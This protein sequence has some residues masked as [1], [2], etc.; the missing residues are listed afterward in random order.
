MAS[1]YI[2][3]S[4]LF[5]QALDNFSWEVAVLALPALLLDPSLSFFPAVAAQSD[6]LWIL[7]LLI[8][9]GGAMQM[10][11]APLVGLAAD[12]W[13]IRRPIIG[14]VLN[15][16][17]GFA[18]MSWATFQQNLPLLFAGRAI[19]GLTSGNQGVL[20]A[21]ISY[22]FPSA[23]RGRWLGYLTAAGSV[24]FILGP[25]VSGFAG[26]HDWLRGTL[27]LCLFFGWGVLAIAAALA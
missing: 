14:S 6:R 7:G 13:G 26:R 2:P 5:A 18:T 27:Y 10:I 9:L 20:Q 1:K 17:L 8:A 11:S 21:A 24:A 23:E 22:Q 4:L 15:T 3:R 16:L 25:L 19:S 12:R